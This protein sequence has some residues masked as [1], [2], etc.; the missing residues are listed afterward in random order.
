MQQYIHT[1]SICIYCTISSKYFEPIGQSTSLKYHHVCMYVYMYVTS[2]LLNITGPSSSHLANLVRLQ[3]SPG[4]PVLHVESSP[5][6]FF[7]DV[8]VEDIAGRSQ[9][10]P[11]W[12]GELYLELHQGTLTSQA[13][14]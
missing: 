14:R 2:M 8:E 10:L 1:Y 13:M 7:R 3:G 4:M 6:Q 11:V 9:R 5:D 12:V